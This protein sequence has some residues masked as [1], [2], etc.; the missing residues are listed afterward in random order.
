MRR[1]AR[2]LLRQQGFAYIAL[3]TALALLG[4]SL[5]AIVPLWAIDAQREREQEL[6]RVGR[7]YARAIQSYHAGAPGSL[8]QYPRQLEQLLVDTRYVG[9]K[10]HLRRLQPD[11][12]NPGRAWGLLQAPDGGII[13]VY[14]QDERR[15]LGQSVIE[16]DSVRLLPAARYSD[17]KFVPKDAQR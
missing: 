4:L 16:D 6:L 9:V 2:G 11:P 8:R 1:P 5:A 15:P 17:W 14:S 13:G 10:R 7:D 12:L 3:I